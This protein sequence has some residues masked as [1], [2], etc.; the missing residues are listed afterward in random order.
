MK[1]LLGYVN[2][3]R[4]SNNYKALVVPSV[5]LSKC[6]SNN[7]NNTF[8]ERHSAVASEALVFDMIYVKTAKQ[9]NHV[10]IK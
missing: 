7:N 5:C 1:C 9:I 10:L 4:F 2:N 8:V 3:N 6:S